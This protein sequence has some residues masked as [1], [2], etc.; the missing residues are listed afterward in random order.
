MGRRDVEYLC[1]LLHLPHP[2]VPSPLSRRTSGSSGAYTPNS[3]SSSSYGY[4][5]S[6]SSNHSNSS[7]SSHGSNKAFPSSGG[8]GV[9][10]ASQVS[11]A[12]ASPPLGLRYLDL[13]WNHLGDASG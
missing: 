8:G 7:M 6:N 3:N 12:N 11:R 9:T 1:G 5:N 13:S 10:A 2:A 4:G